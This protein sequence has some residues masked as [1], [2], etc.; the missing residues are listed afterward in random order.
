MREGRLKR[1]LKGTADEKKI[2]FFEIFALQRQG[3]RINTV[4]AHGARLHERNFRTSE[5][6]CLPSY[7]DVCMFHD[8]L[9]A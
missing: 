6:F 2:A 8:L 9:L 7:P 4:F 1:T 5:N 3:T